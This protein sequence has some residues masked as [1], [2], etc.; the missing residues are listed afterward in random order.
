MDE[1]A[2]VFYDLFEWKKSAGH[3]LCKIVSEYYD[4]F[5]A[6]ILT[7][8]IHS[9]IYREKEQHMRVPQL[10]PGALLAFKFDW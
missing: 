6:E 5:F 4:F 10:V 9:V 7:G 3:V 2:C 1:N 8:D